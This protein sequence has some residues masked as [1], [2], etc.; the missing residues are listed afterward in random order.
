MS[1]PDV[2][3]FINAATFL[4]SAV[5]ILR[6][7]APLLQSEQAITRGHWRDLGEGLSEFRRSAALRT[8]LF[9]FGFAMLALGLNNVTEIF[10]AE[11]ALHRGAFGYG[12]LW[13]GSGVGLVV[14]GLLASALAGE[15]DLGRIYPL[16]FLPW[17]I[18]LLGAGVAPS[19]WVA[20]GAMVV[21]GDR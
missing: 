2:V 15:R 13:T 16:A 18:G 17:G 4:L 10:L 12:L 14:G 7:A 3:Y 20:T 19:I 21:S 8:A 5:L 9:A 1:S 6:I 11:R